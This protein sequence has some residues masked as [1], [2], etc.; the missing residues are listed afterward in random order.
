MSHGHGGIGLGREPVAL[1]L[2]CGGQWLFEG[3]RSKF[4]HHRPSFGE[5]LP[6][7]GADQLDVSPRRR[8][9]GFQLGF[10]GLGEHDDAGE[11]LGEGV[12]YLARQSFPFGGGARRARQ[13]GALGAS[14]SEFGDQCRRAVYVAA[15]T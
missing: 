7:G 10:D 9:I 8:G 4:G 5:V 3:A 13:A 1:T 6:R 15:S 2:D 14:G 11:T 12:V